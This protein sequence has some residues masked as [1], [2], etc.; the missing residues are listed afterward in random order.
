[1]TWSF[2]VLA[3]DNKSNFGYFR[4]EGFSETKANLFTVPIE[5]EYDP[6]PKRVK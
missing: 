6:L 3:E 4:F 2:I 1:M 5:K